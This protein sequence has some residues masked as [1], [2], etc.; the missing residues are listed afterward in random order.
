LSRWQGG[1]RAAN[2]KKKGLEESVLLKGFPTCKK[3]ASV[4]HEA[5]KGT[6]TIVC[7][8]PVKGG[9]KA[10]KESKGLRTKFVLRKERKRG[11]GDLW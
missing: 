3:I 6:E 1:R 4:I 5:G 7:L 9:K 10:R 2:A 8:L 11:L